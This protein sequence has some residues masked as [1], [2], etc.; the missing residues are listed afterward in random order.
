MERT[1]LRKKVINTATALA[2]QEINQTGQAYT[3]ALS[4]A[5]N[6]A[7]IR[8][9]VSRK[10]FIKMIGGYMEQADT[11]FENAID[12]FG[13]KAQIDIAIE[14]MAELTQALSKF[15]RGKEHNVEE[16]IAD[17]KI[18]IKQLELKFDKQKIDKIEK[19]KI[20]R[21]EKLIKS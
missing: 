20:E 2:L 7:C 16:E 21:L 11:V 6:E 3:K 5:L 8:H 12:K 4:K 9:D 15:K 18:M 19:Q 10:E 13:L 1:E 14:E 17:V